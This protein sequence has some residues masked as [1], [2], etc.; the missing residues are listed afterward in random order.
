MSQKRLFT[1]LSS[2]LREVPNG[3]GGWVGSCIAVAYVLGLHN[4]AFDRARFLRDCGIPDPYVQAVEAAEQREVP[5]YRFINDPP[6][7]SAKDLKICVPSS[8]GEG[9]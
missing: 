5:A 6:G 8:A 9:S 3:T 2:A 1:E 7:V 4:R